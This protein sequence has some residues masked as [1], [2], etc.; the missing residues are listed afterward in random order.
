[1]PH[2]GIIMLITISPLLHYGIFHRNFVTYNFKPIFELIAYMCP[3]RGHYT[4]DYRVS[5][6]NREE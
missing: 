1:M 3:K 2:Y 6:L 5:L 4:C